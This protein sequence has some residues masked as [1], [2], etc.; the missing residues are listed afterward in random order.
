MLYGSMGQL[1][2]KIWPTRT[3]GNGAQRRTADPRDFFHP[4]HRGPERT[5]VI[6]V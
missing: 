5:R 4:P 6:A 2:M 3:W 1:G